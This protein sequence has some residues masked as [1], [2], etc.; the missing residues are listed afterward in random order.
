MSVLQLGLLFAISA[1]FAAAVWI[2]RQRTRLASAYEDVSRERNVLG[3]GTRAVCG[4]EI[5]DPE[6]V[7]REAADA[8]H[9]CARALFVHVDLAI[10]TGNRIRAEASA[11][12]IALQALILTAIHATPGG[13]VLVTGAALGDFLHIKIIDD[14]GNADPT[15]RQSRARDAS[16]LI[17]P[18]GGTIGVEATTG[19]GSTVTIC[20]PLAG[21]FAVETNGLTEARDLA[22]QD[23]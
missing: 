2:A 12:R 9:D 14:G 18:L 3:H 8:M 5:L 7:V 17:A 20:L 22:E 13:Q 15:I 6:P 16:E 21:E 4:T 1:P 10:F 23:A 11:L 19:T